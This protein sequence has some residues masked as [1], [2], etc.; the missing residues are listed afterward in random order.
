M[1]WRREVADGRNGRRVAWRRA[2]S[3]PPLLYLHDAGAD[4]VE[5]PA[6][7]TLATDHDV[8][9]LDL[10]G[11]GDSDPPKEHTTPSDIADLLAEVLDALGWP[12]ATVVG[13]SLGGWFALELA[14]THPERVAALVVCD[15][16]GLQVPED[17]LLALFVD[18]RAAAG[19]EH[20]IEQGLIGRL[21]REDRDV[22]SQPPAVARAIIGPFAQTLAAAA[23]CSWHWATANPRLLGRLR[24][25]TCP[26]T[27]LWGEHDALIPLAHGQALVAHLPDAELVVL[28]DTGHL[29]PLERPD[30]FTASVRERTGCVSSG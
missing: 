21:A 28:A 6:L 20:L 27:V 1:D 11:Y 23:A 26:V 15:A 5:A 10:P 13:T 17:Y 12:Q 14:I 25:V 18:G 19:T 16:A 4:T 2:G 3:G 7:A 29:V 30:A 8:V 24:H 9:I 22:R